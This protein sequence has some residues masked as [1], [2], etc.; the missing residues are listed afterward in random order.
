MSAVISATAAPNTFWR[1]ALIYLPWTSFL[2]LGYQ[3][4]NRYQL[5]EPSLLP[6]LPG[7][8]A[9]PFLAWTVSPYFVLIAGM[10]LPLLLRSRARFL[11]ALMAVTLAVLWV[12]ALVGH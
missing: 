9:I 12:K 6:L 4:T 5:F 1:N 7:E 11:E 8:A 2:Y 10:Y 3:L